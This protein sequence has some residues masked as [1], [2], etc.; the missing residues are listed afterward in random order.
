MSKSA[1]EAKVATCAIAVMAKASIAGATKTRLMPPLTADEAA[2]LNTAF[3]RDAVDNLAAAAKF[4]NIKGCMAYA[5]ERSRG[6]F[7]RLLPPDIELFETAHPDFG[8]CLFHAASHLLGAGY[9]SACLLNSDTPTLPVAYLVAAATVLAAPGDRIVIGPARDGGY[10]LIGLK[11]A[12][13]GLFQGVAWS[14][15]HVLRQT[16]QR[17]EALDLEVVSLPR[18]SDVDDADALALLIPQLAGEPLPEH[19]GAIPSAAQH[20]RRYLQSLLESAGLTQRLQRNG[21]P[22]RV[23]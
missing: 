19:V 15:E 10:Y 23:A 11:R 12:H 2:G 3:L 16:L 1:A 17:A 13:P 14:T 22:S 9:G 6:F 5:P 21:Q 18:W 8:A 4:A 20:T 7:E